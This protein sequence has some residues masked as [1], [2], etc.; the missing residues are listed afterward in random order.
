MTKYLITDAANKPIEMIDGLTG[1]QQIIEDQIRM[2]GPCCLEDFRV[3]EIGKKMAVRL[4]LETME[5]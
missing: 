5:D 2:G 3:Y 1:I 4:S